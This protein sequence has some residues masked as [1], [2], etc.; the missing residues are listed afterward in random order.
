M[1]SLTANSKQ[2]TQSFVKY[3]FVNG[4]SWLGSYEGLSEM[5]ICSSLTKVDAVHWQAMHEACQSLIDRKVRAGLIGVG[6]LLG[7][8][9]LWTSMQ[10]C[11]NFSMFK[12][13]LK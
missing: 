10:A 12:L 9:T 7:F 5:D 1:H 2:R 13:L 8:A 3:V 4:P 11:A 6:V